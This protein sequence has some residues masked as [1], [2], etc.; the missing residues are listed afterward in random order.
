MKVWRLSSPKILD[1]LISRIVLLLLVNLKNLEKMNYGGCGLKTLLYYCFYLRYC[2]KC[3]THCP[4]KKTLEV[5]KLPPVLVNNNKL[6]YYITYIM[7]YM[8]ISACIMYCVYIITYIMCII[9]RLFTSR[10]FT[11]IMVVGSSHN[12]LLIFP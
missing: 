9:Y 8:Y 6:Y 3:E 2:K 4:A 1:L 12:V 10:G 5:W 11:F 7:Y